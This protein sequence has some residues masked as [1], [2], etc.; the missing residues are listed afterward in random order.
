MK[1]IILFA[2]TILFLGGIQSSLA[3]E[4]NSNL[5]YSMTTEESI[6]LFGGFAVAVIAIFLF[7]A[8]DSILRR[9]TSYDS[10]EFESKKDKT[11]EKYHSGWTDD[12]VDF[13][14]TRHTEDDAEFSKMAREST[15]PNYYKILGI[16][17]NAS[18]EDIKKRYRELAKKLHP[19]KSKGEKTDD[20]MAE[21]NKAYEILSQKERKEKYDKH[22]KKD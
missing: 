11:F 2:F 19:D 12:Y 17:E 6:M 16:S 15:L 1:K 8:R 3:Q 9:K 14:Y 4:S 22:L 20:T 10:E 21:I 7:L 5:E 18:Q 13:S